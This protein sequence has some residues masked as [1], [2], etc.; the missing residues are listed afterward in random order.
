[1]PN[2]S[3]AHLAHSTEPCPQMKIIS[4]TTAR[5]R[6]KCASKVPYSE[7]AASRENRGEAITKIAHAPCL[8]DELAYD[9]PPVCI[10]RCVRRE[11]CRCSGPAIRAL[12]R[13]EALKAESQ[14]A[15]ATSADA[16]FAQMCTRMKKIVALS[17]NAKLAP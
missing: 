3:A 17:D 2:V 8:Q 12:L 11:A 1:M 15:Q 5:S 13:C 9:E 16:R 14:V 4:G 7:V 6:C 10:P